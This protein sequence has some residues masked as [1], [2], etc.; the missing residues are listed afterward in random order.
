MQDLKPATGGRRGSFNPTGDKS[1][2]EVS[3]YSN[4][5]FQAGPARKKSLDKEDEEGFKVS[6]FGKLTPTAK[7][8]IG[9]DSLFFW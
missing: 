8:P 4:L 9:F 5:L 7:T 3:Y 1:D 2:L 6:Q